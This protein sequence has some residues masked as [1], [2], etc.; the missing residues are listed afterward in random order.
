MTPDEYT[1]Q[2]TFL[3]V[4]DGHELY[5]HDWG[6]PKTKITILF[7]HG[8]PGSGVKDKHKQLFV[9]QK[10]RVIFFDQRGAG[11]SSP[12][13]SL[14]NNTTNHLV[15][16]IEKIAKHLGLSKFIIN[17]GSWGS[18]LAFAYAIKYPK[19][20]HAMVLRGIFTGR[21]FETDHLDK[22]GFRKFF[23]DNWQ[24]FID[25]VPIEY[26]A[27]PSEYH[28]SQIFGTDPEAAKR[29]AYACSQC[30]EGPLMS[31]DDRYTPADYDEFDPNPIRI[32]L[33]YTTNKCFVE[34][35]YIMKRLSRLKMPVWLV[36]GRY[37]MVCPPQ[38][39]FD[40]HNKLP[41][42]ELIWTT[43]G[44]GNDRAN[45]DIVRSLLLQLVSK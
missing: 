42:S 32:E 20:V 3:K 9:P 23:P 24:K 31:L 26:R 14:T 29:S 34:E 21:Q 22:G 40:V 7:L 36:Q 4:G 1:N 43:A 12:T 33:H 15:E 2:E 19:R 41:S 16:D 18:L 17:G 35:A 37:D 30:L 45:Y 27:N 5:L 25:S 6:N 39:A 13:G 11:K 28:H 44:H 38:T 10:Q 8:G